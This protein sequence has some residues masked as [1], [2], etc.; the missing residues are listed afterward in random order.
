VRTQRILRRAE[1]SIYQFKLL[2]FMVGDLH[3]HMGTLEHFILSHH[4]KCNSPVC[5][6]SEVVRHLSSKDSDLTA[7]KIWYEF[8]ESFVKAHFS[9]ED[10]SKLPE[11][12]LQAR[13][14][15]YQYLVV[16]L[17]EI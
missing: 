7:D 12:E 1:P 5:R 17:V 10:I 2:F 14:T 3:R 11:S 6:C 13:L 15:K 4:Q 9:L 16:D 8:L